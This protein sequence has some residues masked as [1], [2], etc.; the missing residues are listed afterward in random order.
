MTPFQLK[1]N[2]EQVTIKKTT[3]VKVVHLELLAAKNAHLIIFI[4][5]P[6][7]ILPFLANSAKMVT[8]RNGLLIQLAIS[9]HK[10]IV[11]VVKARTFVWNASMD[12][13]WLKTP[14]RSTTVKPLLM[15]IA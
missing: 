15:E 9:V 1:D 7:T 11:S 10:Q 2:A 4:L 8:L 5:R 13:F 3:H 12:T 14:N 6:T